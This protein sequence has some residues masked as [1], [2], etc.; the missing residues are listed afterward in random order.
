MTA[1]R[2]VILVA[3]S[4]GAGAMPDAAEY[5]DAGTDTLGNVSRAVGGLSLPALGRMGLGNVV[6]ILGVPPVAHPAA[7]WGR[8][9]E[10]SPGK[11]TITGHWEM[12]GVSLTEPLPI[13][14]QGFPPEVLD[15]WIAATGV[16]GVLANRTASGTQ[17]IEELGEE[18]QRTGKPIVYTSADSVFQVAAHEETVPLETLYAWCREARRIL[19]PL[20]VAR[21]IARPFVGKPGAYQRTYNR[22]DFSLLP[23]RQTVIERVAATGVPVVAVGKIGDIF[24]RRGISEDVHTE[25]NADGLR[26]TAEILGRMDRGFL[27]VNLVDFDM[28]WGHRNDVR[29]YARGLEDLDRGLPALLAR[30]REGDVLAITADHGCD[31]TTPSTDHSREYVPLLVSV[32]GRDGVA[33]RTRSSFADLGATV[34]EYFGLRAAEGKSFLDEV[35]GR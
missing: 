8:M 24:D 13:F 17:I 5:G 3:D 22:K 25:G 10:R 34:A 27:F 31:P 16:P 29:G 12:M 30:L 21:V 2:F 33:L 26:R 14:R 9:A 35:T 18:H 19:D 7:S 4:V 15:P 32:P 1:G 11:D 20:R 23:P 28:L 6:P